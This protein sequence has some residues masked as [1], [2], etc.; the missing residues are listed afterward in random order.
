M[1]ILKKYPNILFDNGILSIK[2]TA[3]NVEDLED[4][5]YHE[6]LQ[7]ILIEDEEL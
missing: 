7:K 5:N 2:D 3:L 1:S 6:E 4:M